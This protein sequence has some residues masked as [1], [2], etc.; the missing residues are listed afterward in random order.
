MFYISFLHSSI[1]ELI[2]KNVDYLV[3]AISLRLRHFMD[4]RRSP[5]VL[6]VILQYS[7]TEILPFIDDTIQEVVYSFILL[8]GSGWSKHC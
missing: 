4:N 8:P 3:N 2:K 7:S 6:K 1:D 5:T